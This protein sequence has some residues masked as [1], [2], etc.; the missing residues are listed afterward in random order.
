M[1]WENERYV[2]VYVRDTVELLALGWEGRA[3][4]WEILRK[5]DRAGV[6]PLGKAGARGLAA[7]TGVPVE[8]V[9]RV[10]PVLISDGCVEM[11]GTNLVVPNFIEAQ[12][13]SMS[14]AARQ[15]ECRERRR[16]QIRNGLR[17]DHRSPVVYFIQ[18]ENGGHVKIGRTDDLAKRL[19]GLSTGRPDALVVLGA[20][21]GASEDE[22]RIHEALAEYRDRGEWFLP[23]PAVMAAA[24]A[25]VTGAVADD[26]LRA[27][28]LVTCHDSLQVTAHGH[29]PS[30]VTP[31][32]T[33]PS[34]AEPSD[35][36]AHEE[37]ETGQAIGVEDEPAATPPL[38]DSA[39]LAS[40]WPKH[41]GAEDWFDYAA[42]ARRCAERAAELTEWERGFARKIERLFATGG[43]ISRSQKETI[44]GIDDALAE[45]D[46]AAERAIPKVHDAR[47]LD[48]NIGR[49]PGFPVGGP[50]PVRKKPPTFD[51]IVKAQRE[52]QQRGEA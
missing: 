43:K 42:A 27:V 45:K 33:V 34:R 18:A 9:E 26:V 20:I 2:R 21:P 37:H 44:R 47:E 15:R 28:S 8:V 17:D 7:L 10:L 52:A 46:R 12:E 51:E 41:E 31:Y 13:A 19:Q 32:R 49:H 36:R 14:S 38:D 25:A 35:P 24:K 50:G 1:H 5:A 30:D 40:V 6:V 4:L 22:R 3:L 11:S 16:D 23:H 29:D 48:P 39:P